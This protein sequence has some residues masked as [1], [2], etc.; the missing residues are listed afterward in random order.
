[1]L[2]AIFVTMATLSVVGLML[3][4]LMGLSR[5]LSRDLSDAA[6][7]TA[8]AIRYLWRRAR[9]TRPST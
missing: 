6:H 2:A 4:G 8:D 3:A 9:R 7:D 1:M 5:N